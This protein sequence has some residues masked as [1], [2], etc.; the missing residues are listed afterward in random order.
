VIEK[1]L[2]EAIETAIGELTDGEARDLDQMCASHWE[3]ITPRLIE[4]LEIVP[5]KADGGAVNRDKARQHFVRRMARAAKQSVVKLKLRGL[6]EIQL[7]SRRRVLQRFVVGVLL[8]LSIGGGLGAASLHPYSWISISFAVVLGALGWVQAMRGGQELVNW[9]GERVSQSREPFTAMLSREYRE[10]VR[11]FFKE[12]AVL[13]D[14]VRG[15]IMKEKAVLKP[16]QT[17]WREL[18]LELKAIEREL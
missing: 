5:P 6:L 14:L 13:F 11:E 1:A 2:S 9:F 17:E 12:Y 3:D 7:D 16:R 4:E 8:A 15:G 18:F 10:G